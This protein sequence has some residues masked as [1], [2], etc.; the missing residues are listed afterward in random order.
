[1][2][3]V[4][5]VPTA[6]SGTRLLEIADRQLQFAN[7]YTGQSIGSAAIT[8]PF[9]GPVTDLTI[10]EVTRLMSLTGADVSSISLGDLSVSKGGDSNLSQVS[11][12]FRN[13]AIEALKAV[14]RPVRFYKALG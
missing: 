3:L 14:G 7:N 11:Q 2:D 9:Q 6:I 10:S 12:D 4:E 13:R 8:L 5:S 1:M